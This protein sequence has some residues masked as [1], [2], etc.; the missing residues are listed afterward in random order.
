MDLLSGRD[1][2]ELVSHRSSSQVSI[3][4]PMH[5]GAESRQ[6]PIRLRN[7]LEQARERLLA[8]G[9]RRAEAQ[10]ILAGGQRLLE[11][12]GFWRSAGSGLA[13]Y[14]AADYFRYWRLPIELPQEVSC[15]SHFVIKPLLDLLTGDRVF[16]V[17]A[18]SASAVRLLQCTA[19]AAREVSLEGLGVPANLAD[20]LQYDVRENQL[21]FHTA[22]R[23]TAAAGWG[24]P[25]FHGHGGYDDGL[26][27]EQLEQFLLGVDRGLRAILHDQRA[28][29]VLAGVKYLHAIYRRHNSYSNLL[30]PGL[31]GNPD[32]ISADDLRRRAWE[33]VR[34]LA[35]SQHRQAVEQFER[36][37]SMGLASEEAQDVVTAAVEGRV[38]VLL[39]SPR[40]R[41]WGQ[42]EPE[43]GRVRLSPMRQLNDGDLSDLATVHTLL[44]GGTVYSQVEE[45]AGKALAA[46]Y[47][48]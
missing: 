21:Q 48:Y 28:P 30:G 18:I 33:I 24:K 14:M 23:T 10:Q 43:S 34:P 17:L 41:V 39:V 5:R 47:R 12:S 37:V 35:A 6:D 11:D 9:M 2:R 4:M 40:S 1:L 31:E 26:R 25:M 46:I 20:A 15:N 27:K 3:L 22:A 29:L 7:L 38:G 42:Y 45:Q 16:F 8:T 32:R 13:L 36:A 44:H 19:Q